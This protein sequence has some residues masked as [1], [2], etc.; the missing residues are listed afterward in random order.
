MMLRALLIL[1]ADPF[2]SNRREQVVALASRHAL[3]A[4]DQPR[5]FAEAGGLMIE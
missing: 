5:E 1:G 3:P 2:L 4:I